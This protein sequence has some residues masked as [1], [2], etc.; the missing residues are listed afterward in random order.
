M[1][2]CPWTKGGGKSWRKRRINGQ[3]REYDTQLQTEGWVLLQVRGCRETFDR[4]H[5]SESGPEGCVLKET[6]NAW[7]SFSDWRYAALTLQ[8]RLH[9][10]LRKRHGAQ[11]NGSSKRKVTLPVL[12]TIRVSLCAMKP[13]HYLKVRTWMRTAAA[14]EEIFL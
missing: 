7:M 4:R 6:Q 1:I 5:Q 10:H 8:D 14:A 3:S 2:F 13:V 11:R 9:K 12:C